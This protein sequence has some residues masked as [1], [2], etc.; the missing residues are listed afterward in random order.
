MFGQTEPLPLRI[1]PAAV[2]PAAVRQNV[3]AMMA[4]TPPPATIPFETED[5]GF[6]VWGWAVVGGGGALIIGAAL[7]LALRKKRK[8][9]KTGAELS[10]AWWSSPWEYT[11]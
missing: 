5:E 2:N 10:G 9:T 11:W 6:P 8:A 3:Q 7:F 1:M 4:A